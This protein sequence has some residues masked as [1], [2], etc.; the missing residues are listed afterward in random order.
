MLLPMNTPQTP[1]CCPHCGADWNISPGKYHCLLYTSHERKAACY[2]REIS[3]LALLA[4]DID[5][6]SSRNWEELSAM[7]SRVERLE[8]CLSSLVTAVD[9]Q[10]MDHELHGWLYDANKEARAAL[11]ETTATK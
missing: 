1:E 11:S 10:A 2:E 5:S 8:N 4:L 7:K 6:E 9:R 3:R